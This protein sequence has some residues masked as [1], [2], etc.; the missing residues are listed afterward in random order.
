[1]NR[2][3]ISLICIIL[4]LSSLTLFPVVTP[5][6]YILQQKAA[7]NKNLK[8]VPFVTTTQKESIINIYEQIIDKIMQKSDPTEELSILLSNTE[9]QE[10]IKEISDKQTVETINILFS[11]QTIFTK[12]QTLNTYAMQTDTARKNNTTQSIEQMLQRLVQTNLTYEENITLIPEKFFTNENKSI[13]YEGWNTYLTNNPKIKTIMESLRIDPAL[14]IIVFAISI[15]IWGFS[16]GAMSCCTPELIAI[17]AMVVE[18]LILGLAGSLLVDL[19]FS[20]NIPFLDQLIEKLCS[21]LLIT[22]T[23]LEVIIASLLCLIIIGTYLWIWNVCPISQ[24]SKVVKAMGG[25]FIVVGPPSLFAW[26]CASYFI[27]EDEPP[28]YILADR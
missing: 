6:Q 7:N 22:Q 12:L 25:G 28:N 5:Q 10:I 21:I 13:V 8:Q 14:F 19:I 18:S 15:G 27:V 2:K 3:M 9:I 26:F 1:M 16:I 4:F 11:K 24:L 17:G 23:Q 20:S